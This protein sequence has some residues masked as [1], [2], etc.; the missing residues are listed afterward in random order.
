MEKRPSELEKYITWIW[1]FWQQ[2]F[3]LDNKAISKKYI[4]GKTKPLDYPSRF[5]VISGYGGIPS[6]V[7]S[8]KYIL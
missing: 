8:I 3:L 1:C 7:L 4:K 6:Q 2:Y 5:Y